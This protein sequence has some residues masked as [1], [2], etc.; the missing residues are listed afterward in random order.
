MSTI[1]LGREFGYARRAGPL[2]LRPEQAK[3]HASPGGSISGR[4]VRVGHSFGAFR[5]ESVPIGG[6]FGFAGQVAHDVDFGAQGQ[7]I[8]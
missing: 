7:A 2:P 6:S 4:R 3:G 5:W 8:P 1:I